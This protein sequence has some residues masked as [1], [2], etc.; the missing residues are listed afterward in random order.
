MP[1]N[2][3][4][5]G[6]QLGTGAGGPAD[7][8]TDSGTTLPVP[9]S[10]FAFNGAPAGALSFGRLAAVDERGRQQS[11]PVVSVGEDDQLTGHTASVMCLTVANGLLFSGSTD[12]TIK[13]RSL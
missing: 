11:G 9:S 5:Q 1:S 3:S 4:R 2:P 8:T 6:S 12:A 7:S 13:V 10:P